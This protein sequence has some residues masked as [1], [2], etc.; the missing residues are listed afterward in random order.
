MQLP[1]VSFCIPVHNSDQF[2]D[3]TLQS[4]FAQDYPNFEVICV[5][6]HSSDSSAAILNKYAGKIKALKAVKKGA[7]AARNLAFQQASGSFI[8]FFDSDDLINAEFVSSQVQKNLQN[9]GSVVVSKW[10]RFYDDNMESFRED[11]NIIKADLSFYDW[12]IQYWTFNNHMTPPGRVLIPRTIVETAGLW[13]ESLSLNDDFAFYTRIFSCARKIVY[14]DE[15]C[16]YYRSGIGGLS[17][18]T[19]GHHYQLS[20]F[21]SIN[22]SISRAVS[23]YPEDASIKKACANVW[24]LFVY[25]NYPYNKDMVKHAK[26]HIKL[27]GGADYA[28]PCGG[29]TKSFSSIFGW[30]MTKFIKLLQEQ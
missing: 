21:N 4:I 9:P 18:K 2:L 6:D 29:V 24:Q 23:K 15:G 28:F 27:L 30:K 3:K 22:E 10:G 7:A 11:Q 17:S 14:N 8:I 13:N 16:F 1:L 12:I 20:N 19:K 5:N 26:D 25:E